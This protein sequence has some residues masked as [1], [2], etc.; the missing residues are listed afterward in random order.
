MDT[1]SGVTTG[2][3]CDFCG[4]DEQE[5]KTTKLPEQMITCKVI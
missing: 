3:Q 4:G 1:S 5:N 2:V